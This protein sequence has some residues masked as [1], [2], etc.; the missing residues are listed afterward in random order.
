M[1]WNQYMNKNSKNIQAFLSSSLVIDKIQISKDYLFGKLNWLQITLL[2]VGVLA[3]IAVVLAL[4]FSFG[5]TT[6]TLTATAT[7]PVNSPEFLQAVSQLSN[8]PVSQGGDI[9][10][11]NNGDE[12]LPELLTNIKSAQHTIDFSVYVWDKGNMSD[13]V[14]AA[15]TERAKAGVQVRV[16]LDSFGGSSAP[17][18][19]FADLQ[20]AGGIVAKFRPPRFGSFA[21]VYK[22]N[23][24]RAIIIDGQTAFLGGMAVSDHW[25]GNASNKDQWRDT[26]FEVHGTMALG[27]QSAFAQIWAGVH[28]EILEGPTFYPVITPAMV[29]QEKT[30]FVNIVS[31]P[32][33]DTQPLPKLFWL[34]IASAKS[35]V[36]MNTPYFLPDAHLRQALIDRAK[37]GVDVR[38]LVPNDNNDSKGVYYSSRGYYENLLEAGVK[39]YEYQPSMIHSKILVIDDTWSVIGSANMDSRSAQLNEEYVMGVQSTKFAQEL[40]SLFQKNLLSSKQII[41]SEWNKRGWQ[42]YFFEHLYSFFIKQY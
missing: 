1:D 11:L 22:R 14:L 2:I 35:K 26:M 15:L 10:I 12:F 42:N 3:F 6:P 13:Q 28:G 38:V 17:T 34:S 32:A 40:D 41:L 29:A 16:L 23:H 7:Y 31:S 30:P 39:I 24:R 33:N 18:D 5:D 8:S 20:K 36:Y 25:L 27:V 4:F 21:R 37:A 9:K 19:K